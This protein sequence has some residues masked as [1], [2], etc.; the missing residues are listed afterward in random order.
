MHMPRRPKDP[1]DEFSHSDLAIASSTTKRSVQL[2]ADNG[3]LPGDRGIRDLKRICVVGAFVS[4]G[5]PMLVAGRLAEKLLWSFNQVDGE[6]PSGLSDMAI[7]LNGTPR[8]LPDDR[9]SNDYWYHRDLYHRP[10]FYKAGEVYRSDQYVEIADREHVYLATKIGLKRSDALDPAFPET[11]YEGWIEGWGRGTE[12]RFNS[13]AELSEGDRENVMARAVS[14]RKNVVGL[15]TINAS[16]AIRN[17]L[18]RLAAYREGKV[19]P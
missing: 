9:Q 8:S 6:M 12:P 18:D 5:A 11:I 4:A 17:G 19:A 16:L 13:L 15:L 14:A 7:A 3:L 10:A 1:A 2:I